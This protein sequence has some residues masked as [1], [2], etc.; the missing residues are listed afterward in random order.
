M[1]K[2]LGP[3]E[4]LPAEWPVAGTTGYDYLRWVN[5]LFVDWDGLQVL[6]NA[7][8]RFVGE[9]IDFRDVVH[10][11]KIT[12]LRGAMSSELQ[13]LARRLNRLSERHRRFRDFTL[14]MLRYALREIISYFAVYR[15]YLRPQEVSERDRRFILRA[16]AQAKRRNPDLAPARVRLRPRRAFVRAAGAAGRCRLPRARAV[17]GPLPAGHQPGDGQGGRGHG[18]LP[19]FSLEFAE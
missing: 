2:I 10:A 8:G 19:L 12:I 15:T 1:E 18:L 7:Y 11:S 4:P 9:M 16:T 3:D 5:G 6:T 14:N 13:L 17:R